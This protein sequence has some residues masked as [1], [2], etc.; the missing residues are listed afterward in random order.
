L[1][2]LIYFYYKKIFLG[3]KPSQYGSVFGVAHLAAFF[4]APILGKY[5]T[6]SPK[7]VYYTGAF[8]QGICGIG[9]G[10]LDFCKDTTV[11]LCFSYL[12]RCLESL[13]P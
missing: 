8:I 3:A 4:T 10:C 9:F 12:L 6:F 11:F 5:G 2:L 7:V 13:I 1:R